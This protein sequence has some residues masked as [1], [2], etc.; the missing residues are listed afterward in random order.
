MKIRNPLKR[1]DVFSCDH[2][3]H[4]GFNGKVSAYHVLKE[5]QCFPSGCIYFLWRCVRLEKGTRC[6]HGYT[7]PG[8]KCKGCTHYVEEKLHFQPTL[9]LPQ[10]TYSQ[11]LEEI[12]NYE[13]WLEKIRFTRQAIAGKIDT[14]KPWFEKYIFPDRS[15]VDL[16]GY[17]LVF[18]RGFI[19]MDMFEDPF[20]VR[21]SQRQMQEYGFLPKMKVEMMA[22]I[23]EDRGRMIMQHI[24]Q[25]EKK[26][27]GLGWQWTKDKALVAVKTASEF[28]LQPEK[29]FACSWGALVDVT[30]L[31]ETDEK[32]YRKLFCLKGIV[33]PSVCYIPA[34]K[35]LR[36]KSL[37]EAVTESIPTSQTR[38]H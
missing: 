34:L 5:K 19:G 27:K 7:T 10:E 1:T 25:V 26:T 9:L 20:Y 12:E 18:K 2:E 36:K 13:N 3:A 35:T 17:L 28:D 29:C 11:F 24:S 15:R 31:S 14:V 33:D 8:R 16:R 22:E 37:S 21:I 6:V 23:R 38:S 30:E 4:Q 32:K